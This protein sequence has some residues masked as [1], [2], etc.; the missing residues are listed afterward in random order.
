MDKKTFAKSVATAILSLGLL[1]SCNALKDKGDSHKCGGK[2]SC[3]SSKHEK[4]GCN[5][6]S[7]S[8]GCNSNGCPARGE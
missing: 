5:S 6:C 3:K 7:S 2:N 1:A 8:H 4:N